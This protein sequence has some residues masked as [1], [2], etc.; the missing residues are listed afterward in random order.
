MSGSF[1]RDQL[2]NVP[3]IIL[4]RFTFDLSSTLTSPANL[5]SHHMTTVV[6]IYNFACLPL[7]CLFSQI[8][9]STTVHFLCFLF[10]WCFTPIFMLFGHIFA[11]DQLLIFQMFSKST[12][13]D[14]WSL[15]SI[16]ETRDNASPED[17]TAVLYQMRTVHYQFWWYYDDTLNLASH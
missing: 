16:S 4:E 12:V 8:D 9:L 7:T 10:I 3:K 6:C 11:S 5:E 14:K 1:L 15:D 2:S 13:R 17:L